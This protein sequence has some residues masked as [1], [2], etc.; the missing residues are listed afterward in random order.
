[1]E[2]TSQTNQ[3]ILP[4]SSSSLPHCWH[5][6]AFLSFRGEDTRKSFTDHLFAALCRA[7]VR[8]FRDAEKLRKGEDISIDLIKAIQ[9]SKISIIVFS[10]TYASSRWC[11]EELVEIVECKEKVNQVVFPIFYDVDPSEVRK[12]TGG[13]GD[14]LAQHQQQ[15][16]TKK[17]SQWKTALTKVANFSG[18]DLQN[19][20]D[21]YESKFIDNIVEKVL[22]VVNR[23][24]LNVAKYPVGIHTRVREILS[25]LQSKSNGDVCM[26]G[27][28]GMGG[29]G[30]TTLA[31]A[32]Y[33]QI[34]ETFEGSCFLDVR[35]ECSKGESVGL[36]CLQKQ[37]LCNT[38]ETMR[39]EVNNVDE[40]I[41]L[42]KLRL[43][44][45]RVLIVVDNVEHESQLEA[46]VGER[47]WFGSGSTILIT[48]RNVNLL[49]G[50]GKDCEKYNV[51]VLRSEESLQLFCWH[52][53]KDPN[54]LE[55]FA[56]LSNVIV[57]YAHGLPL[58]LTVL[59]SHFRSRSSIQHWTNDFEKL[60]KIPHE[61]ILSILKISYDALD[62]DTQ[63]IFL[64]IA[65][66]F[67]GEYIWKEDIVKILNACGFFAQSGVSTLIDRCLLKEDLCM[68]DLIRD[69][70]REIVRKESV[71]QPEKRS[72]LFLHDE[73]FDVLVSN[74]GTEAIETMIIDL[75]KGV[76]LSTKVF[77]KMNR[78]RLL[79]ILSMND[80]R[81]LKY[82]SDELRLL[83]LENCPLKCILSNLCL[84]RLV[85]LNII[86]S[87][88]KEFQ[89]NLQHFECLEILR[90]EKCRQ[91]KKVPSFVGAHSL[92]ILSFM[93]CS[94]LVELPRSIGDLKNLVK[95][96]MGF[97]ENLIRLPS[98][99]GNLKS[100]KLLSV[101]GCPKLKQ[102]PINLGK[103]EQLCVLDASRTSASDKP[104]W[105][106]TSSS[107]LEILRGP[108][109][110]MQHLDLQ[111]R[112]G[113]LSWLWD[114][115]LSYS[116]F[117]ALPFNLSHHFRLRR[118]ELD[119][120]PNLQVIQDLPPR[121]SELSA[122]NCPILESVQGLSGLSGLLDLNLCNCS[123][124][125]ELQGMENL[126]HLKYMDI[127]GCSA[128]SSKYW[129]VNF[130][131]AHFKTPTLG[132]F[133]MSVSK[134][135]VPHDLWSN[136]AVGCSSANY[137]SPLFLNKKR[138][139]IVVMIS[140]LFNNWFLFEYANNGLE[141]HYP[142]TSYKYD[143]EYN[144][145]GL[146]C[147]VYDHFTEPNKVEEVEVVIEL[148]PSSVEQG[149]KENLIIQTCIVHEEEEDDKVCFYPMNPVIKFHHPNKST[150]RLR[151][152]A[153][154][155][156]KHR[157]RSP[158]GSSLKQ[159]HTVMDKDLFILI[160]QP[161]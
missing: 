90:L 155:T 161:S 100:L 62:D 150:F 68:H 7:G 103:L 3:L 83:Y 113:S 21:G 102:L 95:L 40:G 88:I 28:Y 45:K 147:R 6:D 108:Y 36:K 85:S 41:S 123:N 15:F 71:M 50:L 63:R 14:A 157:S 126:V 69:M 92:K 115:D 75:S 159:G 141:R 70:G 99:I 142:L 134:D 131:K 79:K 73:V 12:Q 51:T 26:I 132:R 160:K 66:F 13:F 76:H 23:T 106:M 18:W 109:Q 27:I 31:K 81:H 80:G 25:L 140:C 43:G 22:H 125:I 29:V 77:S 86:S 59:G 148:N 65:C 124:L 16:G 20:A 1:M 154:I 96:Q 130:F 121:L 44:S 74:K 32:I 57:S 104:I 138:I 47:D 136:G 93:G 114:L 129:C 110:Y 5:Y 72:R 149:A 144:D 67:G 37:L 98:S 30:K 128:L 64:D 133:K 153:V 48:T 34:S 10:K 17:V 111:I 2:S 49:N 143:N 112:D 42:I 58:A 94:N 4:S 122:S 101:G 53:F 33:N 158:E 120:C 151:E 39:F 9:E 146:E 38:L 118:L 82:L 46:L 116:Y 54:P 107:S 11:L 60:R 55:T 89:P 119:N 8:T 139:F 105:C 117:H 24:F 97:C 56:E 152:S 145:K 19:D 78:L 91:L 61:D 35:S 87:T 127:R 156:I 52:A 135:M 84:K 137:T